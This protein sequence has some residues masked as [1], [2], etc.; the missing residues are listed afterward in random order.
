MQYG[1]VLVQYSLYNYKVLMYPFRG[2]VWWCTLIANHKWTLN[3][4]WYWFRPNK[5]GAVE[6]SWEIW[7]EASF[8]S[9]GYHRSTL[10]RWEIYTQVAIKWMEQMHTFMDEWVNEG[11]LVSQSVNKSFFSI[12]VFGMNTRYSSDRC[13][14][15]SWTGIESSGDVLQVLCQ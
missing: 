6:Q 10:R 14:S 12:T 5:A 8:N 13:S 7:A 3:V 4:L 9:P 2:T 15:L 1:T 11:M